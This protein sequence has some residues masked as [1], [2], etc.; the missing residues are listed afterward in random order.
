[1]I[2]WFSVPTRCDVAAV[3]AAVVV[4]VGVALVVVITVVGVATV[5]VGRVGDVDVVM[6]TDGVDVISSV[7][8]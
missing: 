7:G 8:V 5:V 1:L 2:V 4:V 3:G 6:G